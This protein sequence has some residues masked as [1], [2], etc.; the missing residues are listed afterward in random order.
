LRLGLLPLPP[1]EAIVVIV[2]IVAIYLGP[3][4]V[5]GPTLHSGRV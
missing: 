3:V 4:G 1:R 2:A 5:A